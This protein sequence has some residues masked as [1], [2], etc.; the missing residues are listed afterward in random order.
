MF[1]CTGNEGFP[2][3]LKLWQGYNLKKAEKGVSKN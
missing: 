2:I 1:S 3:A